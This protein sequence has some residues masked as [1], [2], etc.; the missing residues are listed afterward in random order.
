MEELTELPEKWYVK[1][2]EETKDILSKWRFGENSSLKLSASDITGMCTGYK[3]PFEKG[4]NPIYNTE[5][6]GQEIS[7][8]QFKKW[9][10]KENIQSTFEI[11]KWYKSSSWSHKSYCKF[12]KIE[13]DKFWFTEKIQNEKLIIDK[14][15]WYY[16]LSDILEI[17]LEEIQQ[18][19][20]EKHVDK[21]NV[22]IPDYLECIKGHDDYIIS[23]YIYNVVDSKNLHSL[24]LNCNIQTDV[25]K[26]YTNLYVGIK[27]FS[28]K[29]SNKEAYEN[30][31][32]K[33]Y[34]HEVVHCTT[35]EEW[36]FVLQ[37]N[38]NSICYKSNIQWY[39]TKD[40]CFVFGKNK[41]GSQSN[42]TYFKH[43]NSLILSFQE[44]CDKFGHVN[45]FIIEKKSLIGRYLKYI[46]NNK[47]SVPN[48]G[49]Y[50]KIINDESGCNL[51]RL[52]DN[53]PN[54]NWEGTI[55]ILNN[56]S[57][58]FELMPEGFDPLNEVIM[59]DY[60]PKVGDWVKVITDYYMS[61]KIKVDPVFQIVNITDKYK[62]HSEKTKTGW[63]DLK[64]VVKAKTH[65]IPKNN[66]TINNILNLQNKPIKTN[67]VLL[68]DTVIQ[69]IVKEEKLS[70]IIKLVK[71]KQTL[72]IK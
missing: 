30:Q 69:P 39:N 56:T 38:K 2:T 6:F 65:E 63:I 60:I 32:K 42:I 54:C 44:W 22:V 55:S 40:I 67:N 37:N 52:S 21:I 15:W 3:K 1:V 62:L 27:E 7:F 34:V 4:H 47:I 43:C 50:F 25:Y 19:L 23:G 68:L 17:D 71:P 58:T 45:P 20:P 33:Q 5:S 14:N 11:G 36:D 66:E 57:K 9:V 59:N 8:E 24:V 46:G 12:I 16:T 53:N 41:Y 18:Y 26:P 64:H 49:D 72:K 70:S 61:H 51:L 10:L 28:F 13:N 48:Y 29:E 35:Q 31:V